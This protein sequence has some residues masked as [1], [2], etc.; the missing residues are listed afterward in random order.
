MVLFFFSFEENTRFAM[1]ES[2]RQSVAFI[3]LLFC[4]LLKST[5]FAPKWIWSFHLRQMKEKAEKL[6]ISWSSQIK[7][8][9]SCY[10]SSSIFDQVKNRCLIMLQLKS[11]YSRALNE[12]KKNHENRGESP[13]PMKNSWMQETRYKA[14]VSR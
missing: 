9:L 8:Y 5:I 7:M 11:I 12:I 6:I 2:S 13:F 1:N 3:T 10:F 14:R 4:V